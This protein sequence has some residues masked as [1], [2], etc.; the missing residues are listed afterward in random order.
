MI[1]QQN[2]ALNIAI[3]HDAIDAVSFEGHD[4]TLLPSQQVD[5]KTF[6]RL[7]SQAD[8][9]TRQVWID[10]D[11]GTIDRVTYD[12]SKALQQRGAAEVK[13]AD[14]EIRY[15]TTEFGGTP[16]G[17]EAFAFTPPATATPMASAAP[18]KGEM[19]AADATSLEGK[20]APDIDLKDVNGNASKLSDLKG[21]VVVLDFWATWCPPCRASLPHL[22]AAA[23]K[24]AGDGV[25]VYAVNAGEDA[26]TVKKYLADQKLDLVAV[27]DAENAA[28]TKYAVTGIPQTVIIDGKGVVRKVIVG[29]DESQAG[30][31]GDAIEAAMK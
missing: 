26:E 20:P 13:K 9:A 2:P 15:L 1:L 14:V 29:F 16:P 4:V 30:A 21:H 10:H 3:E 23:K 25:K 18:Q 17:D 5:G 12:F 22:S 11:R 28:G 7:E 27:L 31:V 6:D 24:Y 19:L 8:G